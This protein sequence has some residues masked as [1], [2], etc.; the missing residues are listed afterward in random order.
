MSTLIVEL[1]INLHKEFKKLCIEKDTDMSSVVRRSVRQ[2]VD[3][4]KKNVVY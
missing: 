4:Q 3:D 1:N 2:W